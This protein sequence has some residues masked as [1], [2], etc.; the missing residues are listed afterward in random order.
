MHKPHL[1]TLDKTLRS[2]LEQTK[3]YVVLHRLITN[4]IFGFV[5]GRLKF[6]VYYQNGINNKHI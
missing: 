2:E 5:E 4:S 6:L 3:L 1:L